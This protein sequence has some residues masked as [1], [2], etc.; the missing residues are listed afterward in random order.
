MIHHMSDLKMAEYYLTHPDYAERHPYVPTE[1]DIDFYERPFLEKMLGIPARR[2]GSIRI[3]KLQGAWGGGVK[4]K[5]AADKLA[6][7]SEMIISEFITARNMYNEGRIDDAMV[8][9]RVALEANP[10]SPTLLYDMGVMLMKTGSYQE[11]VECF[12]KSIKILK[13]T[14]YTNL[15]M[16]IHPEVY[17]GSCVN[18]ALIYKEIGMYDEAVEILKEAIEFM[19]DDLDANWNLGVVY[20]FMGD[21]EKATPQMRRCINLD[22]ENDEAHNIIGLAYYR[23]KLYAAAV[24]EFQI[25]AKLYPNNKQYNYNVG[26]VMARLE[27]YDAASQAFERAVGLMDAEELHRIFAKQPRINSARQR[28]NDGCRAMKNSNTSKAIECFKAA[29]EIKPD[30]L[31]ALVNLGLCY[32]ERRDRQKQ[33]HYLEEAVR[34]NPNLATVRYDLGLAYSGVRMYLRAISEFRKATEIN[35]SFRDAHFSLGMT[36]CKRGK[37]ADAI[38]SFERCL[39]LSPNWSE[40]HTNL[41]TCYLRTGNVEGAIEHFGE[42]TRL[43]PEFAEAHYNLGAA[44]A[45][46]ERFDEASTQFQEVLELEPGHKKSRLMQ[47]EL[48]QRNKSITK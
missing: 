38:P 6:K 18:T 26:V 32:G 7:K 33:I 45:R 36:L 11:A 20:W 10:E 34:I 24:S 46:A 47:W 4:A 44:Y 25:A 23:Q 19:P 28:Y 22:P 2:S 30:M 40:A 27:R 1:K 9:M 35:P 48:E 15:N 43:K 39:E 14:G 21:I 42:A 5:I 31:E 37:H 16:R 41:G 8:H 12:Q 3:T 13:V 17:M 29:L